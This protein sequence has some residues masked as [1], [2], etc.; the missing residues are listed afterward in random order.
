MF[1]MLVATTL[2]WSAESV[3]GI[4]GRGKGSCAGGSCSA[5]PVAVE[6]V[7]EKKAETKAAESC[8]EGS[9]HKG[10]HKILKGRLRGHGSCCS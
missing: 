9:C 10:R 5:T 7:A 8:T 4:F 3:D 1:S 6:P 2:A